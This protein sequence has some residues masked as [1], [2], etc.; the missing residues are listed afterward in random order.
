MGAEY[1]A[2]LIKFFQDHSNMFTWSFKKNVMHQ[3]KY[4]LPSVL[5]IEIRSALQKSKAL[6]HLEGSIMLFADVDLKTVKTP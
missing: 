6:Q 2:E 1:R 4:R 5:V 3:S